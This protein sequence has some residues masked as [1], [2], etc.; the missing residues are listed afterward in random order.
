M[1]G[2]SAGALLCRRGGPDRLWGD[3]AGRSAG[4]RSTSRSPTRPQARRPGRRRARTR[5]RPL[6]APPG[7][8]Q[9]RTCRSRGDVPQRSA[10]RDLSIRGPGPCSVRR[11]A[12]PGAV[13]QPSGASEAL[14]SNSRSLRIWASEASRAWSRRRA[15]QRTVCRPRTVAAGAISKQTGAISG[16]RGW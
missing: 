10:S 2:E 5:R 15:W 8:G 4:R 7:G 16:H 13:H 1:P 3:R 12:S 11:A 6:R 9:A 14:F